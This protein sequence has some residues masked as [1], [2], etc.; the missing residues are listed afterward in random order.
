MTSRLIQHFPPTR[1]LK[2]NTDFFV[3]CIGK[4]PS[5]SLTETGET[6]SKATDRPPIKVQ[7]KGKQ[8]IADK[9]GNRLAGKNKLL[10]VICLIKCMYSYWNNNNCIFYCT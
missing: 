9:I 10:M 1:M 8:R 7:S 4:S 3:K 6:S 2:V 5:V